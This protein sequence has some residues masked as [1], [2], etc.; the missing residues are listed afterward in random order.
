MNLGGRY[1]QGERRWVNVF[2]LLV[3]LLTSLP[4]VLGYAVQGDDYRFTGFVFGVEDGNSYIAKMLSGAAGAWLFRSPYTTAPQAGVLMFPPYIL[5]GKL[6]AG[7]GMHEQLVALFQLFR[8]LSA[9]LLIRACYDFMAFFLA[10]VRLRRW[11]LALATLGGGLGWL[12]V[13]LGGGQNGLES[14]PLEFYSPE[15]FGFLALFGLP[16]VALARALM[17]WVL[18]RYLR[19]VQGTEEP[20]N[21]ARSALGSGFLW[22]LAGLLQPLAALVTGFVLALH[23]GGMGLWSMWRSRRGAPFTGR[24]WWRLAGWVIMAGI[25]PGL[26]VLYQVVRMWSDPFLQQW[27]AQNRLAS[28]GIGY[29]LLAYGLLLP[30]AWFGGRRL[31]RRDAWTGWLPV[32]WLLALPLLAYFPVR[33]QRRLP[34][35]IW[36]ARAARALAVLDQVGGNRGKQRVLWLLYL[37]FPATLLLWLG[38]LSSTARPGLPL[39]RP[40][41]EVRAF[42]WLADNAEPGAVTL[43]A[44]PTG[45]ALPAW[46]P[47]R[48]AAGL[49]PES[50]GLVDLLPQVSAFYSLGAE[51][52]WRRERL[53]EWGVQYVFWGPAERALGG[54]NPAQAAEL[55][56]VYRQGETTIFAV[57]NP[58]P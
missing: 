6:A 26:F 32:G 55:E 52:A 51:P 53:R 31:L 19:L 44:Y 34:D 28:P 39:F 35:G 16:H 41:D 36:G 49:G 57:R 22:L 45:N 7:P 15:T 25:L 24:R 58:L 56:P 3:M 10:D 20:A 43:A 2:A 8:L 13:L 5:L 4:Y 50:V 23:L 12:L 37:A 48:V 29:Y 27:T 1:S 18:L 17:L 46:A 40:A 33:G 11:G 54:W 30:L 38:G 21:L 47:L 14:L 42:E 9:Y